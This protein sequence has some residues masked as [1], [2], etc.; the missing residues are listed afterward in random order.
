MLYVPAHQ[1]TFAKTI[2]LLTPIFF[3]AQEEVGQSLSDGFAH[4][5]SRYCAPPQSVQSRNRV[6][7]KMLE[8]GDFDPLL[9]L[10]KV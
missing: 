2:G 9:G 6:R 1:L 4:P 3:L 8:D 7:P 10:N 5:P